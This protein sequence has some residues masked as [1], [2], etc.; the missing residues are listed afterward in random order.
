[1]RAPFQVVIFPFR[2]LDRAT[3]FAVFRRSDLHFWQGLAG[4]GQEDESPVQAARR[5][6]FEE[7]A[8]PFDAPY[9]ALS[10]T[11]SV[12][13]SCIGAAARAHWPA[14]LYV[15]PN[16]A[17]GVEVGA[18]FQPVL[19]KEHSE[20]VWCA[21]DDAYQRL[22]FESNQVALEELARRIENRPLASIRVAT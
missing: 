9:F 17:F 4:G 3:E 18:E 5:E 7:A 6:A 12:P 13:V 2:R 15:I 16:H 19:S 14:D 20:F 1:M 21:Y 8:V 11:S 10:W 22:H